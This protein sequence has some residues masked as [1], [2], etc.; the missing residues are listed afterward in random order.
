MN[1]L[2]LSPVALVLVGTAARPWS[3]TTQI[4]ARRERIRLPVRMPALYQQ[5]CAE[6]HGTDRLGGIG[7]AL[8]PENFARLKHGTAQELI[9]HGRPA[10]QMPAFADRHR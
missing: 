3:V 6:C 2:S 4:P 7:P 8:L 9:L 5:L 1:L 10:S